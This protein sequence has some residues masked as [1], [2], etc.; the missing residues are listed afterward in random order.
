MS[1]SA[2]KQ[3]VLITA[4]GTREPID[5]VRFI[6]NFSTGKTGKAIAEAFHQA[7][8]NVI[9]LHAA[10]SER[11]N[12]PGGTFLEFESSR[13]LEDRMDAIL[14]DYDVSAVVHAA[15][16]SDYRV[17]SLR[18]GDWS[19]KPLTDV[20]LPSDEPIILTLKP[21]PKIIE[22]IRPKMK[23]PKALLIGFKLTKNM[24]AEERV[25]A[26][27]NLMTRSTANYVVS[28][29]L[30]EVSEDTHLAIIFGPNGD[31]IR[32]KTKAELATELVQ[33]V[34]GVYK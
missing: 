1:A 33:L 30:S 8:I 17:E 19:F 7:G 22:K 5:G 11:P 13:D 3:I 14:N 4:G 29:D 2:L 16:V 25:E 6:T 20:K 9:Y 27:Q 24:V 32:T 26:A 28:N 15:A 34:Q 31:V 10:D 18:I 23:N 21:G 12:I